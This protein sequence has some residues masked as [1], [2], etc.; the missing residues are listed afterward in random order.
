MTR[1]IAFA[2]LAMATGQTAVYLVRPTTSYRLLGL[3]YGATAV[4]IVAAAFAL[5]PLFLAIPLGRRAD[6]RHGA[7][8]LLVGCAVEAIGCVLLAAG[9]SAVALG[10]ASGVVGIGHLALALGAQAVIARESDDERHDD[11]FALLA[12]GVSG[13]QL[14]GPLLGGAVLGHRSGA[15]LLSATTRA[16]L[17]AAGICVLATVLAAVAERDRAPAAEEAGADER[18]SVRAILGTRGVAGAI[19]ASVAV[20]SATDVFTAY[21]PLVGEHRNIGP[22]VIGV[23]LALRAGASL[24]C[25][26]GIGRLVRRFGRI[27]LMTVAA[28][29]A[30]A[31]F[32]G[33]TFTGDVATLAALSVVVGVGLGF[34]Q[35]LSMTVVVQLVPEHWRASAL[36]VRLTGNRLGQVAAPAAAGLV[37]GSAGASSVFWM[38]SGILVASGVAVAKRPEP[39]ADE[40]QRRDEH[41]GDRLADELAGA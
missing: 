17:V 16:M 12:A 7:R 21:M 13:G 1:R 18:A 37:A 25:R 6:R 35:P 33:L 15:A 11:H 5:V 38:T 14:V 39:V 40:V 36:A 31:A 10:A 9:H 2:L 3:H 29:A 4:G 32:T 34:A 8:L 26:V 41:D 23:L 28:A 27:E 24:A 22:A 19:F 30:A 20:L